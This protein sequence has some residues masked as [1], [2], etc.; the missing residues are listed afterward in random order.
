MQHM[1]GLSFWG[2]QK[3]LGAGRR[4]L[5]KA[6]V[7]RN[8][9][10]HLGLSRE[11]AWNTFRQVAVLFLAGATATSSSLDSRLHPYLGYLFIVRGTMHPVCTVLGLGT[12]ASR[13]RELVSRESK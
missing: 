4:R 7:G 11:N 2:L 1:P 6:A 3:I 9:P 13:A 10:D 5:N 8:G 12:V